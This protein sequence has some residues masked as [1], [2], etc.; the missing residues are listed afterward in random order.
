VQAV[1]RDQDQDADGDHGDRRVLGVAG[2]KPRRSR[3]AQPL[4]ERQVYGA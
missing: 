1:P 4:P 2:R 3:L